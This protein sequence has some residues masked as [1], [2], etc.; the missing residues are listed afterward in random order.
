MFVFFHSQDAIWQFLRVVA[1]G[2]MQNDKKILHRRSSSGW[3]IRDL[4]GGHHDAGFNI[5]LVVTSKPSSVVEIVR[6]G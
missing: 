1:V 6:H 3:R 4:A 2:K 5:H